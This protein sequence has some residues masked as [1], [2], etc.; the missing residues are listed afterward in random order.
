M[1]KRQDIGFYAA[2]LDVGLI[3]NKSF[4]VLI[5]ILVN[6]GFDA[7]ELD[8]GLIGNKSFSFMIRILVNKGFDACLL[9]TSRC[10]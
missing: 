6:K 5:R 7:A 10:V 8:V 4:S 2:D 9:Y 3:G 1:Y